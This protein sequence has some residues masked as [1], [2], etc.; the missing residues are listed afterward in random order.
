MKNQ[1][2]NWW[3]PRI[4]LFASRTRNVNETSRNVLAGLDCIT[5]MKLRQYSAEG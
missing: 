4:S 5:R 1:L 3:H 2:N